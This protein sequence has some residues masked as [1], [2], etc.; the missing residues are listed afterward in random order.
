MSPEQI[1][2]LKEIDHR[3]DIYSLG[4]VLFECLAGQPPF[5][6]RN[7]AVVLQ[8]HLTQP[9]PDLRTLRPE[10]PRELAEAIGRALAKPPESRW[11][12]AAAMRESLAVARV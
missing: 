12:T 11:Q 2:A 3:S 1:T 4:C 10:T 9:A 7:E 5:I 6:H 8:L